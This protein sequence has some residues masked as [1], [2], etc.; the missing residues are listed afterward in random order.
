MLALGVRAAKNI[1]ASEGMVATFPPT[2]NGPA[3]KPQEL[4]QISVKGATQFSKFEAELR[5]L[6]DNGIFGTPSSM[7]A[8][9]PLTYTEIACI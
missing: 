6:K 2:P 1:G 7:V 9:R 4:I 5:A 3:K 8:S